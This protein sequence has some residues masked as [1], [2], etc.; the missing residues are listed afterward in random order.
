MKSSFR[1]LIRSIPQSSNPSPELVEKV[2]QSPSCC[3]HT[4]QGV[5]RCSQAFRHDYQFARPLLQEVL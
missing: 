5:P 2:E 1:L 3:F 4:H